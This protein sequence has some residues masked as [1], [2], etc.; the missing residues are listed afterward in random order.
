MNRDALTD[1]REIRSELVRSLFA[2]DRAAVDLHPDGFEVVST[3]NDVQL[4][5]VPGAFTPTTVAELLGIDPIHVE[6][7][8]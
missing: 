1:P 4:L 3:T 5:F 7:C 2:N 6:D 8:R